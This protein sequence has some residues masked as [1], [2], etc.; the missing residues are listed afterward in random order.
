MA[1]DSPILSKKDENARVGA[2]GRPTPG[3]KETLLLTFDAGILKILSHKEILIAG[4]AGY[5]GSG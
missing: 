2:M 3:I 4:G 1:T 5:I